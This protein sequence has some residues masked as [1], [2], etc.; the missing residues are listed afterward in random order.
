MG[1]EVGDVPQEIKEA[2]ATKTGEEAGEEKVKG[3][4]DP[5][6]VYKNLKEKDP[7]LNLQMP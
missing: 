2:E 4:K 7:R 6:Q 1:D 5:L 3:I